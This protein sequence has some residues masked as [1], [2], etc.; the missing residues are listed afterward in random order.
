[1]KDSAVVA[2]INSF[3]ELYLKMST[4]ISRDRSLLF[5]ETSVKCIA[6]QLL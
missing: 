3:L 2:F 5:H 1:M 6:M 4:S